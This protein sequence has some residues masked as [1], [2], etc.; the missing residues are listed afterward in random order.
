M[1]KT[2][3]SSFVYKQNLN[4][5]V[6]LN[7]EAMIFFFP[8]EKHH[9]RFV[10]FEGLAC[11]F[12]GPFF[13]F[14]EKHRSFHGFILQKRGPGHEKSY[15]AKRRAGAFCGDLGMPHIELWTSSAY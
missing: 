12:W 14:K 15:E 13:G 4:F 11:F 10:F 7:E 1:K 3:F 9:A 5:R 8:G 2:E 6:G